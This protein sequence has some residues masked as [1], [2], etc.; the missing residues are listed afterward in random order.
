[1]DVTS[2]FTIPAEQLKAVE[3]DDDIKTV[4][5]FLEEQN[6]KYVNISGGKV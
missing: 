6:Y 5:A 3:N 1:M 2:P 4:G